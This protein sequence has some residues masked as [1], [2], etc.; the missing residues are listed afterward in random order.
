MKY[1]QLIKR[2]Q[3][4]SMSIY[5]FVFDANSLDA[6]KNVD[7]RWTLQTKAVSACD[8]L[9]CYIELSMRLGLVSAPS[10]EYWEGL[11]DEIKRMIIAL[12]N[13]AKKKST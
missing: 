6:M 9:S 8:K 1:I 2:I 4:T 13:T 5:E 7:E 10:V 3:N 12:R 11:I